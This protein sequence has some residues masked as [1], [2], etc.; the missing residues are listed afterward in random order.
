MDICLYRKTVK[1]IVVKND[2][3]QSNLKFC[4]SEVGYG[5]D[6]STYAMNEQ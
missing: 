6:G 3:K 4:N 2:L 5:K 1:D